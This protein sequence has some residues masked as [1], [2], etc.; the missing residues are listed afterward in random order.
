MWAKAPAFAEAHG[1]NRAHRSDSARTHSSSRAR[2]GIPLAYPPSPQRRLGP[3]SVITCDVIEKRRA[4][5]ASLR[6]H[7]DYVVESGQAVFD[8]ETRP[9][10]VAPFKA[11]RPKKRVSNAALPTRAVNELA[12]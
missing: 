6:W 2:S 9:L 7:D 4:M 12:G 3:M 11:D 5:D 10:A 8:P 1:L